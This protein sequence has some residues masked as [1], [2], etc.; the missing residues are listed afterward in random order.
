[1]KLFVWGPW[2][3]VCWQI[4]A[5][6]PVYLTWSSWTIFF[7][8]FAPNSEVPMNVISASKW[9][10]SW[11]EKKSQN[12]LFCF[13]TGGHQMCL[14]KTTVLVCSRVPVIIHQAIGSW[15]NLKSNMKEPITKINNTSTIP[16]WLE[17]RSLEPTLTTTFSMTHQDL[18]C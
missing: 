10:T 12:L 5:D 2:P 8:I 16:R 1:M 17:P 7:F 18:G 14:T 4:R 3:P 15:N 9:S 11:E 13:K 6:Q